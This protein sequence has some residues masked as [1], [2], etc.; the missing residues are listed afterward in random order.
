MPHFNQ[1]QFFQECVISKKFHQTKNFQSKQNDEK[2]DLIERNLG[3][4]IL[5]FLRGC[6]GTK[7]GGCVGFQEKNQNK[8]QVRLHSD[9]FFCGRS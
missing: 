9:F 5:S 3:V 4:G 1:S 8:K 7:K 2:T 6:T